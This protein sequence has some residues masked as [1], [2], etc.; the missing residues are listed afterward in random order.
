MYCTNGAKNKDWD[1]GM[2]ERSLVTFKVDEKNL[3][4][5][6][7]QLRFKYIVGSTMY[8]NAI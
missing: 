8:L 2:Y 5:N 6:L 3:R 4:P 7:R 1:I